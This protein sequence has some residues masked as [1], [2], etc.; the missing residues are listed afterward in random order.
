MVIGR[1][2]PHDPGNVQYCH[3]VGRISDEDTRRVLARYWNTPQR[4]DRLFSGDCLDI[5]HPSEQETTRFQGRR[6][7]RMDETGWE[8]GTQSSAI[9]MWRDARWHKRDPL[10]SGRWVP[11]D[12]NAP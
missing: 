8:R 6:L 2:I 7:S 4:V 9:L 10:Y 11:I 3:L 1:V 5:L 12:P